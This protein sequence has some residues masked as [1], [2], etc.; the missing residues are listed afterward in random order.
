MR[1]LARHSTLPELWRRSRSSQNC[2]T[3]EPVPTAWRQWIA[4]PA[5][6]ID[7]R[8]NAQRADI[9]R[10]HHCTR[11]L[12]ARDNELAHAALRAICMR[13]RPALSST[14]CPAFSTP[15]SFCTALTSSG[16]G[17]GVDQHRFHRVR[18]RMRRRS[19]TGSPRDS[20]IGSMRKLGRDARHSATCALVAFERCPPARPRSLSM[21]GRSAASACVH[22][23]VRRAE[24][25]RQPERHAR[26]ARDQRQVGACSPEHIQ[27][28]IG[29]C[30][31]DGHPH[32]VLASMHR[33]ARAR[34]SAPFAMMSY[35]MRPT[36]DLVCRC[37]TRTRFGS[38]IGV[39]G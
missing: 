17:S 39:S 37:S 5:P 24:V 29:N 38:R 4:S 36:F 10:L 2:Q 35:R 26:A 23:Q 27:I 9:E 13:S 19:T 11:R 20:A 33:C 21:R 31:G 16:D 34:P 30:V 8:A 22:E 6:R 1:P 14:K 25:L 7:L 18:A 12:T 15:N 3:S 28:G 32:A